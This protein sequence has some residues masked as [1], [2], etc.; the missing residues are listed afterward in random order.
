MSRLLAAKLG[1]CWTEMVRG[2]D[3]PKCGQIL[4]QSSDARGFQ[5]RQHK[6]DSVNLFNKGNSYVPVG[7]QF[8]IMDLSPSGQPGLRGV[9]LC[10]VAPSLLIPGLLLLAR[11]IL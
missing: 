9:I 4:A 11:F 7:M 3:F 1:E 6:G 2:G 8:D 10:P 5:D